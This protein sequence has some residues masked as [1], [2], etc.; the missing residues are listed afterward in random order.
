MSTPSSLCH[1]YSPRGH[2]N[3]YV[4]REHRN[5]RYSVNERIGISHG[6][7]HRPPADVPFHMPHHRVVTW[8]TCSP[9]AASSGG[10]PGG[11]ASTT[12]SWCSFAAWLLCGRASQRALMGL[13]MG[14]LPAPVL[15]E[16]RPVAVLLAPARP[17]QRSPRPGPTSTER[18]AGGEWQVVGVRAPC[19]PACY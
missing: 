8:S 2:R 6:Q 16:L 7:S 19:P 14:G 10:H 17:E 1:G 5:N 4:H 15:R 13:Q 12:S 9:G 11:M 18:G 3:I